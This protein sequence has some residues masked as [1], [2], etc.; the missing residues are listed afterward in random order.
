[1]NAESGRAS[2]D[3][4]HTSRLEVTE[5]RKHAGRGAAAT[6]YP[7]QATRFEQTRPPPIPI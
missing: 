1:M 5:D 7:C 4:L 6:W 2:K 3:L